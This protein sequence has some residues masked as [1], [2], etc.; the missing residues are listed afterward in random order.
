MSDI[1]FDNELQAT[2][3]LQEEFNVEMNAA[4]VVLKT[5]EID[6]NGTYV[7]TDSDGFNKVIANIVPKSAPLKVTQNM[8][9]YSPQ[10]V[11]ADAI[12]KVDVEIR[13][14][15]KLPATGFYVTDAM[16]D[17]DGRWLL[18]S[19]VDTS[20][21]TTMTN[22]CTNARNLTA[23]DTKTWDTSN[24]T[25]IGNAFPA[26]NLK[27]ID[28]SN[29]DTRKF[30][31]MNRAFVSCALLEHIDVSNWDVSRV[32]TMSGL[33]QGCNSLKMLDFRN[34]D[35]SNCTNLSSAFDCQNLESLVGYATIEEV[36]EQNIC[37]LKGMRVN[38]LLK[39]NN[40]DRA[41]FRAVINGLADL[42][43]QAS[44]SLSLNKYHKDRF[45]QEDIDLATSK[46]WTLAWG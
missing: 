10:D 19:L 14:V 21:M 43:G 5:L 16:L 2:F 32:T 29:W 30:T 39:T 25:N 46:N 38:C 3:D 33:F 18:D 23:L 4:E 35:V 11:G 34:W 44:C 42:T 22:L 17:E 26:N 1:F 7:P 24:V 45:T 15:G 37:A 41:S 28:V 36:L 9:S 31:N 6:K 27:T 12:S 20:L 8:V 40:L 13:N